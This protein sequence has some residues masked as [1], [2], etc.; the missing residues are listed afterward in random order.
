MGVIEA[1]AAFLLENNMIQYYNEILKHRAIPDTRDGLMEV[2]RRT[3]YGAH[4]IKAFSSKPHVKSVKVVSAGLSR[5]PHGDSALYVALTNMAQYWKNH[6]L[7]FDKNG[8]VGSPYGDEP[9]AMRY[10]EMRLHKNSENLLLDQIN[11]NCVDFKK[12]FDDA[13]IEPV[14]LPAKLPLY[15]INGVFGISGG[16]SVNVPLHN[17]KEVIDET[18]AYIKD[19]SH[20]IYLR[21]DFPTGGI[22]LD[23]KDLA[24]AYTTGRS[25]YTMRALIEKDDKH[26]KLI[27]KELHINKDNLAESLSWLEQKGL[28]LRS[29]YSKQEGYARRYYIPE[30]CW[31]IQCKKEWQEMQKSLKR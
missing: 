25:K 30:E 4:E 5:H 21:P 20:Q 3:I 2:Q 14:V 16:Y 6:I 11:T 27:I 18:I 23:N 1:N 19:K 8:S 26:N 29:D 31:T 15:L 10:L 13:D 28:V 24:D 9:A 7:L 22:I 12:T 17:P